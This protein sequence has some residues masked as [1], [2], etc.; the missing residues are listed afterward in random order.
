MI[1]K[2]E[3]R[4][5]KALHEGLGFD[6]PESTKKIITEVKGKVISFIVEWECKEHS[7]N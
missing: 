6:D 5:C 2:Y 4:K 7:E 1:F 3:C